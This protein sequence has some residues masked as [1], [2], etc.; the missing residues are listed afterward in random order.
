M[1]FVYV[2][3]DFSR[4]REGAAPISLSELAAK[5]DKPFYFYDV[6]EVLTRANWFKKYSTV[7]MHFAMKSNTELSLLKALARSG[8]GVDVVSFGEVEKARAAEFTADKIIYSGVAKSEN[9]LDRAVRMGVGQINV[10][11]LSE[12]TRIQ[13]VAN[14][15][16]RPVPVA[17]RM[18]L[19]MDVPTHPYI[20]TS[21]KRSK[22][23]LA[24]SQLEEA[25]TLIKN[26][27][28]VRLNGLSA[29]I[30]SQIVDLSAFKA[31]ADA[32][33]DLVRTVWSKG[34]EIRTLDLGGG[35][36]IDYTKDEDDEPRV[37]QYL[38]LL[39][40]E[41]VGFEK[42]DWILE[43]GRIL[44]ARPGILVAKVEYVKKTPDVEFLILN[45]GTH[46][47]LRPALYGALH[48]IQPLRN[49]TR[50]QK[51]YDV[52]GLLCESSDSFA[53]DYSMPEMQEGEWVAIRDAGAY[54]HVMAS[55]YNESPP[56]P[57]LVVHQNR[58]WMNE[59][60]I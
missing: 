4:V 25:L 19:A 27:K 11:S 8:Y 46:H 7:R 6:D 18:N 34:F 10:E 60:E 29:H 55:S 36:G 47:L 24:M 20:Q 31:L 1:A 41:L 49:S 3:D 28:W 22:F 33:K 21:A 50:Q 38:E 17:L 39:N 14:A 57:E 16:Q 58:I 37:K 30:G 51:P 44:T 23:G 15:H 48:R 59:K 40:K 13:K 32:M 2:N 5:I 54:G 56:P 45:T 53:K 26:D 52:V 42:L 43:P 12:L 35:L 9:D